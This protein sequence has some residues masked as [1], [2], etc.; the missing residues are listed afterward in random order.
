MEVFDENI[1]GFSHNG[2]H[3]EPNSSSESFNAASKG[4]KRHQTMNK[5]LIKRI[6][7]SF[8]K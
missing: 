4:F 6:D 1:P 7:R 8:K 3:W 5:G 2:L